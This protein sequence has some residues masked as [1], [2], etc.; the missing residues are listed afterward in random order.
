M[1]H[2]QVKSDWKSPLDMKQC[3]DIFV[4]HVCSYSRLILS[5]F[6]NLILVND[7]RQ[8]L[9]TSIIIRVKNTLGL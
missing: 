9:C 4:N 8:L 1:Y 6:L 5:G 2:V 7:Y 3:T